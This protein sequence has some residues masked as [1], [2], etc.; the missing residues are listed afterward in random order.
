MVKVYRATGSH[1]A[2]GHWNGSPLEI[3]VTPL[4]HDPPSTEVAHYHDFHEYY[5]VLEGHAD[6]EVESQVVPLDAGTVVMVAPGE[7][8]RVR[9]VDPAYGVRWVVVKERSLPGSKHSC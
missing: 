3:G 2:C 8:H 5:V 7:R 9:A 4:L 6:L 1:L